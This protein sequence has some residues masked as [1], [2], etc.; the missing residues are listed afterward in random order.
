VPSPTPQLSIRDVHRHMDDV[1]FAGGTDRHVGLELEWLTR[2]A[3]G[4]RPS[5][6]RL[7][8]LVASLDVLPRAG[9]LSIEPGGQIELSTQPFEHPV[10]AC[11]AAATDLYRLEHACTAAG[12]ELIALG[13]DPERVPVRVRSGTP[14]YD[15]M[16]GYFADRWP[17]AAEMMTN[18]ASIQLN[19][20][21][22]TDE[23]DLHRRWRLAN[24]LG[25]V[26]LASFAN[27]PF[28]MGQP[29][30]WQS[31]RW[32]HWQRIDPDRTR[33]PEGGDLR[34]AWARY[35]LDAPVMLIRSGI[36][37]FRPVAGGF[38]FGRWLDEGHE[39]GWPT[40]D[41]L[42]YHLT[43]LFP[44]VRP[45][46]W[47]ELRYLDTLP[48][49]FWQVAASVTTALLDDESLGDAAAHAATGTE[50]LWADAAQLGLGHPRLASAARDLFAMVLDHLAASAPGSATEALVRTYHDHWIDRGRSPA[51]DR[52]DH[53]RRTGE[54]VPRAESP[55]PYAAFEQVA[56]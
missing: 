34:G 12:I 11:E 23:R 42:R 51:D 28:A 2:T 36:D 53:W 56:P 8:R 25:P 3:T 19:V 33:I 14:R 1:V 15:A 47:F 16:A 22:G 21:Y 18:T 52:L 49:P 4:E 5:L 43:T 27:S 50:A 10:D 35:A 45:R 48:T 24:A 39:L 13:H 40:D 46:G 7:E 20:G 6:D 44:P 26:L 32:R 31:T 54:V 9:L 37:D 38:P 55:I 29:S 41:D 17:A 30:G